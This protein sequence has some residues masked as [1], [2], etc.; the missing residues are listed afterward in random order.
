M[1]NNRSELAERFWQRGR[2]EDCP[3]YDM[4]AHMHE[5]PGIYF[6]APGPEEMIRTMDRC[7]TK[8]TVFCSHLALTC[9]EIGESAN[10]D[11]V[12]KHPDR[13]R[14]YHAILAG[15]LDPDRD[16]RRV[17]DNPGVYVGY[18]FL[19]DYQ[20]VALS[21]ERFAPYFQH[22]H[23]RGLLVL[24]HTW[25]GSR[26]DGVDEVRK[27]AER[28]GN[29]VLICGH[30]FHGD[31]DNGLTLTVYPNVYYE[32]TAVFDDRGALERIA[33]RAGSKRML[34]GTDLPWFSTHHGVGALLSA[35]MDDEDYRN[36]LYR[37]A[38]GLLKRFI[39]F[40]S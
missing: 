8:L 36:V 4:H 10:I 37:N 24:M 34:F 40:T 26:Y 14:A 6:P 7:G 1:I 13:F 31:W 33:E 3:I 11:P 12:R 29:A 21:D 23:D 15:S 17:E 30:S 32:L 38:E 22:A 20:N 39:R 18:K 28:Y 2:L 35:D 25:G 9:P 16:I 27:V 19:L 5:F